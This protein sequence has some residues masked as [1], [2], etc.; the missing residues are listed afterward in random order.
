MLRQYYS[1]HVITTYYSKIQVNVILIMGQPVFLV[2]V[3]PP[4]CCMH[5]SFPHRSILDMSIL[6]ILSYL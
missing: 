5:S 6:T 3:S 2:G 4:K 1:P